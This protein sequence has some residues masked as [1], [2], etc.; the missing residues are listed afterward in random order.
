MLHDH[1]YVNIFFFFYLPLKCQ[2]KFVAD[3][4]HGM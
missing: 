3:D 4:L 2:A 1:Q